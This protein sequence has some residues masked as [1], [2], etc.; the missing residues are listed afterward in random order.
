MKN[1]VLFYLS[2]IFIACFGVSLIIKSDLGAGPWDAFFVGMVD[3]IGLTIGTW[4]AIAQVVFLI[5]NSILL[6]KRPQIESAVTIIIWS[7]VIDFYME[8]LLKSVDFTE[9]TIILKSIV[10]ILGVGIVSIGIATY[11]TSTLPTMPYDGT[12]L[13]V[14]ERFGLKLNVTRTILE[15]FGLVSA[16]IAS[17]PIGL[18]TV[19][20]VILIG[21]FIQKCKRLTDRLYQKTL[22]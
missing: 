2:G 22:V 5:I 19:A 11:I 1:K 8:F 7:L 17:G 14:S 15:G 20:I 4:V 3:K 10:F 13:A 16:F 12:M 21:P 18:G 9:S 6:K